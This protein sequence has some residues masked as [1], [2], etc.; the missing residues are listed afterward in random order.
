MSGVFKASFRKTKNG[1]I[2]CNVRNEQNIPVMEFQIEK[3]NFSEKTNIYLAKKRLE[4]LAHFG[5][6]KEKNYD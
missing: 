6:I 4:I 1:E 3:N 5:L 2:V